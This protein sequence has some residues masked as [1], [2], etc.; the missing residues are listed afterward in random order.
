MIPP[1]SN[2][3]PVI[4]GQVDGVGPGGFG[5]GNGTLIIAEDSWITSGNRN[6]VGVAP[7]ATMCLASGASVKKWANMTSR[8]VDVECSGSFL[9]GTPERPIT[10]DTF[11]AVGCQTEGGGKAGKR[12]GTGLSFRVRAGGKIEVHSRDPQKARAVFCWRG[13]E[14]DDKSTDTKI[15]LSFE[16]PT[17]FNGVM[18]DDLHKGGLYLAKPDMLKSWKNVFYGKNNA[19]SPAELVG[20]A[21]VN[22]PATKDELTDP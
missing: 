15:A 12:G 11:L 19:A 21:D 16:S 5:V 13:K 17:V 9:V 1:R 20:Q 14:P 18:F 6:P 2:S 4:A 22:A 7:G 10:K 8:R 3:E